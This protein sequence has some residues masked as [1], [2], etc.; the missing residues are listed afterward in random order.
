VDDI[1]WTG[2]ITFAETGMWLDE[3]PP[4]PAEGEIHGDIREAAA[5]PLAELSSNSPHVRNLALWSGTGQ[6]NGTECRDFAFA[7][8]TWELQ[9]VS[10]GDIVCALTAYRQVAVLRITAFPTDGS[11][12][13]A[14]ATVWGGRPQ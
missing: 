6:P 1:V 9:H 5:A 11:G 7:H 12:V 4:I 14:A 8:G 13:T 10:V 2:N 3:R